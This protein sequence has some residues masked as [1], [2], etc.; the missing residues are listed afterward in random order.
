MNCIWIEKVYIRDI[1]EK[2]GRKKLRIDFVL[3]KCEL[4]QNL[5][6]INFKFICKKIKYLI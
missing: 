4:N 2:F 3:R 6:K 5:L 1:K